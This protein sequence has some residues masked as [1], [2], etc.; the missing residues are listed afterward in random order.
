[1]IEHTPANHGNQA[2]LARQLENAARAADAFFGPNPV[3]HFRGEAHFDF[4]D[5][6]TGYLEHRFDTCPYCKLRTLKRAYGGLLRTEG[7]KVPHGEAH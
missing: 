5:P 1:M 6:V 3:D 4:I 7:R 2:E